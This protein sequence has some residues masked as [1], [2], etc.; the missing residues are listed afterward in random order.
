MRL[1]G[2]QLGFLLLVAEVWLLLAEFPTDIGR[3]DYISAVVN[4][5]DD[6]PK[7]WMAPLSG[8][9]MALLSS[10]QRQLGVSGGAGEI[11]L[12][13][14][15]F[16][17]ALAHSTSP[18]EPLLACDIYA[19]RPS[20]LVVHAEGFRSTD[21]Q[22][23][24]ENLDRFDV[25]QSRLR[26]FEHGSQSLRRMDL[27]KSGPMPLRLFS[28]DGDHGAG[29]VLYDLCLAASLLSDG[30]V[31]ALDD[32]T[33]D[34]WM[35][36]REGLYSFLGPVGRCGAEPQEEEPPVFAPFLLACNKLYLTTP[37]THSIFFRAALAD[38][39][40]RQIGVTVEPERS[41][42]GSTRIGGWPVVVQ[43]GGNL[44]CSGVT[45]MAF[46]R[47]WHRIGALSARQQ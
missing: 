13:H 26:F 16:F 15:L 25:K 17:L 45:G 20:E 39:W 4:D 34:L 22:G 11:G 31:I 35:G 3:W 36:V 1:P 29:M 46:A 32:F 41:G 30:G 23:F 37:S 27:L 38:P 12:H 14:G 47:A 40:L 9:I 33:N 10:M 18:E 28:V 5:T 24:L 21:K 19:Q 2:F 7:G 6:R 42:S 44:L 43:V 8:Y